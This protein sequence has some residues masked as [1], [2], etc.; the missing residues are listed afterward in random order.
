MVGTLAGA[1][2]AGIGLSAAGL[3]FAQPPPTAAAPAANQ[4]ATQSATQPATVTGTVT[5]TV[6][7]AT[8]APV[9]GASVTVDAGTTVAART[10]AQGRF[11]IALAG[12]VRVLRVSHPAYAA[13]TLEIRVATPASMAAPPIAIVLDALPRFAE[14]VTVAAVRADADAPMTTRDLGR[15]ELESLNVGQEM[16]FLLKQVPSLTQYSDSG[17]TMGYSTIFLRGIP[18]SRMNV[19]LDGVP[20]NEPEDSSFYFANAGDFANA[21]GSLQVQRGV[22][23]STVGA[24]SFVGS[25]NFASIDFTDHPQADIRMGGGSFGTSRISAALNSGQIAGG[26]RLYGQAAFQQSDGFR[27]HSGMTQKSLYAGASQETG[28]SF[29]KVF[30]FVGHEQSQLSYY[31]ADEATLDQD[32]RSNPMSPD[33]RDDFTQ[34]FLTAQYRRALG[35]SSE[36]AVQGYYNGAGGWYRSLNADEG[37]L[38][39]GLDWQSL[40][41]TASYHV[42]AGAF[43]FTWGGHVNDFGSLH[44]RDVVDGARQ[45]SN[46]GVKNDVN[47]FAKLAYRAG[48]W[49]HYGDVQVRWARFRYEGSLDLGD[50]S[51]TFVNPKIG[52][53]YELGHGFS[54]YGS[55]GSAGREP[56]RS[57]MLQGEDNPSVAYDLRAVKP[58]R[59]VN[60]ETGID[61]ARPGLSVQANAFFM[62]FRDE[63]AQTGELS[64]TYLP[65]RRNVDR[66]FRRGVEIDLTWR[67]VSRVTVHHS[68]T[69]SYNRIRSW[70]QFYDV[71]DD[72]GDWTGSTNRTHA[73]VTP[74]LTPSILLTLSADYTPAP[75]VTLGAAGR[76]VGT[77]HLDN[78]GS[79]AYTAPGFFGLDADASLDLSR[80][81]SFAAAAAPKLRL[82]A[83]NL[84]DNR[85]MFPSG[86]SYQYFVQ[87]AGGGL[88]PAGTRYFYPLATRS[89]SIMLDLRF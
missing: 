66:S 87:N 22:G 27:D 30:G 83:V 49:H 44:T 18:Q 58:E 74:L 36:I 63:I 47:S 37:L 62:E 61:L 50:V 85:R 56:G 16:P 88:E 68:A 1:W 3:A 76:Y 73:D 72:A 42:A 38:Q 64:E 21:L 14:D 80:A 75:W 4:S 35:P 31:A 79:A 78:T 57:D 77:S 25:I 45:Y 86:Y 19:T 39:Y 9:D 6:R 34:R 89:V 59:V 7:T 15:Q 29:F 28:T 24:A 69:F 20:L 84:L 10:D 55:L 81:L 71:Y 82:H 52:T 41:A 13:G 33:E 40:G 26:L 11:S 67:P 65:L 70:T 53:R 46:R 60:V 5:G 8:G 32:L 23:T 2:L 17:S 54:L 43:D 51:W 48:R 12:G